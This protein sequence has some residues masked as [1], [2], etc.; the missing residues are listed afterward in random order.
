MTCV[1][2]EPPPPEGILKSNLKIHSVDIR[3]T[4][5]RFKI[6]KNKH[7]ESEYHF[8]GFVSEYFIRYFGFDT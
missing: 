1:S 3:G 6:S 4:K 7:V 2:S 8:N 5:Q